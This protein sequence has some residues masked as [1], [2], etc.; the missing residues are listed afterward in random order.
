MT[1]AIGLDTLTPF[2]GRPFMI[3]AASGTGFAVTLV[4]ATGHRVFDF[5]GRVRDPFQLRF[6]SIEHSVG[7]FL[8]QQTY[9]VRHDTL[10]AME[11]FLVPIGPP[12][13]GSGGILY[14]S[15]FT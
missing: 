15:V 11:L 13:D 1:Q 9:V 3:V 12:K 7:C 6:K 10:G 4:Q 8:A 14:Q 2:V 5:P